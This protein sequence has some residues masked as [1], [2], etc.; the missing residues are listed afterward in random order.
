[1]IESIRSALDGVLPPELIIFIISLLPILE[2]RGGLLAASLL[3][4]KLWVA[5]P[6]CIIGNLLPIP[7]ILLFIRKILSLLKKTKLFKGIVEWVERKADSKKDKITKYARWG[8]FLF[9]AIP[10]PGTGAW[11]GALI[12]DILDIHIKKSL[13]M[14]IAGVFT[15]AA[16]MTIIAYAAPEAFMRLIGK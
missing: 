14:I 10:I 1:M 16:I 13:P 4:V 8:L 2:L 7:F 11:M 3:G 5:L 6:I 15:A 9:V 12:A